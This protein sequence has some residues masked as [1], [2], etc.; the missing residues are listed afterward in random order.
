MDTK[1][2]CSHLAPRVETHILGLMSRKVCQSSNAASPPLTLSKLGEP[3][4]QASLPSGLR[5]ILWDLV[6]LLPGFISFPATPGQRK[7]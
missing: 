3:A 1:C 2:S 7:V 6:A 4:L 5:G